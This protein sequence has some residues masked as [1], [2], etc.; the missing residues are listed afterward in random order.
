MEQLVQS[1]N[2]A[3]TFSYSWYSRDER[4]IQPHHK[5]LPSSWPSLHEAIERELLHGIGRYTM[6]ISSHWAKFSEQKNLEMLTWP[7]LHNSL[8]I[9]R[10]KEAILI[11]RTKYHIVRWS[12]EFEAIWKDKIIYLQTVLLVWSIN[13]TLK[14]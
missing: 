9:A 11:S 5:G 6:N 1:Q 2:N 3:T 7:S 14:W 4:A 13:E 10:R 12:V 8:K